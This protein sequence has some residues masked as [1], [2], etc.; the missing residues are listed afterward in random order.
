M[1]A[2]LAITGWLHCHPE[3]SQLAALHTPH[4]NDNPNAHQIQRYLHVPNAL[5][6]SSGRGGRIYSVQIYSVQLLLRPDLLY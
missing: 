1:L 6:G 4:V 5:E 2:H 3:P